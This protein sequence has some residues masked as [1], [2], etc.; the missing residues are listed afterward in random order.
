MPALLQVPDRRHLAVGQHFRDHFID[1]RVRGDGFSGRLSIATQHHHAKTALLQRGHDRS[2]VGA[3]RIGDRK[4][5]RGLAVDRRHD[6]A[7]RRCGPGGHLLANRGSVDAGFLEQ[8]LGA[9]DH[10]MAVDGRE[11]AF[12]GEREEVLDR[13]QGPGIRDQGSGIRDQGSGIRDQGSGISLQ[14]MGYD[15]FREGMLGFCLDRAN[16]REH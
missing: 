10:M 7:A 16:Y 15:G 2:S 5:C 13:D 4:G 8:G 1:V 14:G 6:D 11:H 12:A 9:D 3:Q